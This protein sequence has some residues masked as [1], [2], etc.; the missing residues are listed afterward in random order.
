[1]HDA[2]LCFLVDARS[3][4]VLL[5]MKKRGFGGGKYNGFGGKVLPGETVAAAAA[6]E[7]QEEAGVSCPELSKVGELA[8]FFP[9]KKEWDQTVHVFIASAWQ[10]EPVESDEMKPQWFG[11]AALPFDRMWPDDPYWLPLVLGGNK[12]RAEF[13]FKQDSDGANEVAFKRVE[14]VDRLV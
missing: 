5:G 11:Y 6:R 2:T 4:R 1:M 3:Q 7:L 14:P 9:Q 10:G 8:F 13:R 12:V